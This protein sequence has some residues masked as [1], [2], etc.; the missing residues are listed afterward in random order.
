METVGKT[1]TILNGYIRSC[2]K[3]YIRAHGTIYV[4]SPESEDRE[5]FDSIRPRLAGGNGISKTQSSHNWS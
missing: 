3:Q 1:Q 4:V 5:N 2:V